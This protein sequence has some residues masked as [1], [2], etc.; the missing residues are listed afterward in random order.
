MKLSRKDSIAFL[1]A[2]QD[3]PEPNEALKE[4]ARQ[5]KERVDD[6]TEIGEEQGEEDS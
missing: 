6:K 4:A 3:P 5:Y 2:L 1:K